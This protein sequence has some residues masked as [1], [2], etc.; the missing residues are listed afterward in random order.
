LRTADNLLAVGGLG[1]SIG[2]IVMGALAFGRVAYGGGDGLVVSAGGF[3]VAIEVVG[4][5]NAVLVE[6][7]GQFARVRLAGHGLSS[8][9][10]RAGILEVGARLL[11]PP[12]IGRPVRV[13]VAALIVGRHGGLSTPEEG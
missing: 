2:G 6:E 13:L 1:A 7:V 11:V 8:L 5:R 12:L 9:G 10:M 4:W 3:V